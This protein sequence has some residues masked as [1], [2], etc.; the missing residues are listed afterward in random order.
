MKKQNQAPAKKARTSRKPAQPKPRRLR[1]HTGPLVWDESEYLEAYRAGRFV[2]VQLGVGEQCGPFTF[3][4]FLP[5]ATNDQLADLWNAVPL[6]WT[7]FEDGS[8][9]PQLLALR[10]T[11][12]GGKPIPSQKRFQRLLMKELSSRGPLIKQAVSVVSKATPM[13]LRSIH[14]RLQEI[15]AM[16]ND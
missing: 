2:T 8:R 13:Q 7:F 14:R 5:R 11:G 3:T 6:C 16:P 9:P 12:P 1:I 15:L 4:Q 10:G